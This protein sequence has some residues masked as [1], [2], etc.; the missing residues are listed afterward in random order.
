MVIR[1]PSVRGALNATSI[2]FDAWKSLATH[3]IGVGAGNGGGDGGAALVRET[4]AAQDAFGIS[5]YGYYEQVF[6]DSSISQASTLE[7]K[8]SGVLEQGTKALL[9][10]TIGIVGN[11]LAL[12]ETFWIGDR[13]SFEN[14]FDPFIPTSA[15]LR[16][17]QLDCT[18]D[19]TGAEE[20]KIRTEVY[21]G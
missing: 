17:L 16:V 10:P 14:D 11:Q 6:Q 3:V 18:I 20:L 4:S 13:F 9:T 8:I 7:N 1:Y 5:E 21:N 15:P 19:D 2:S 12:G